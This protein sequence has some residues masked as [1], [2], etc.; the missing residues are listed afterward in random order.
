MVVDD[1]GAV[2]P[3]F[4]NEGQGSFS[5]VSRSSGLAM[6][7]WGMGATS[8][9]FDG[10]G[11]LDLA[12]TNIEFLAQHR[13]VRA[14]GDRSPARATPMGRI[15]TAVEGSMQGN[16]LFR[17]KGDGTFEEVGVEAGIRWAGEAPAG[18][19]FLDYNHD[20]RPDL[21]VAN[22]SGRGATRTSRRPS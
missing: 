20:G 21:Y 17:G 15:L 8:A 14:L 2:N 10:D 16:Q 13:M 18:A 1:S 12:M 3:I 4:R 5:E 7:G 6:A 19:E 9:D 11:H 22:A